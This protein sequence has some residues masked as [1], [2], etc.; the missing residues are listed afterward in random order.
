MTSRKYGASWQAFLDFVLPYAAI[1]EKRDI[2]WHGRRRLHRLLTGYTNVANTSN[3]TLPPALAD[4]DNATAAMHTIVQLLPFAMVDGAQ[5][6]AT[7][8]P[9]Q[10]EGETVNW[11]SETAPAMLSPEQVR[12]VEKETLL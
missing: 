12:A 6:F 11:K 8:P 9:V 10:V 1:N 7:S 5:G 2:G 4:C 3:T